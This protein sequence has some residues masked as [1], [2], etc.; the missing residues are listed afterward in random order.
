MANF[1]KQIWTDESNN[2]SSKRIIG[3]LCV[4]ALIY[5]LI[6]GIH[7]DEH[8]VSAVE[9]I[10]IACILGASVDKA[11]KFFSTYRKPIKKEED[12]QK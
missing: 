8:V 4:L 6:K 10:G 3:T 5:A 1:F 11:A 9:Y 12:D 7:A 2:G